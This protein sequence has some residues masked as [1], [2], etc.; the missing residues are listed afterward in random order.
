MSMKKIGARLD[1]AKLARDKLRLELGFF[2]ADELRFDYHCNL[3]PETKALILAEL[4]SRGESTEG[5][6]RRRE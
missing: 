3:S 6:R 4:Q 2:A 5:P 1:A